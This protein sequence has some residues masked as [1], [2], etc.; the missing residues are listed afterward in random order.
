MKGIPGSKNDISLFIRFQE[1]VIL[2][3]MISR[4][5]V[6]EIEGIYAE[7]ITSVSDKSVLSYGVYPAFCS[8]TSY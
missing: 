7:K 5:A 2:T 1:T 4:F 8:I 6:E 3:V